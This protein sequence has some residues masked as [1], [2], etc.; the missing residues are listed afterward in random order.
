LSASGSERNDEKNMARFLRLAPVG[1]TGRVQA[2]YNETFMNR[3]HPFLSR[4]CHFPIVRLAAALLV[5]L[6]LS[7]LASCGR[8]R[9]ALVYSDVGNAEVLDAVK[10]GGLKKV[11]ALLQHNP[12]LVSSR[13][14]YG[15]TPLHFAAFSGHKDV[16]ELLLAHGADVNAKT[17][18]GATPLFGAVTFDKKDVVELLLAN[19]AD[20]NAKAD[21]ETPLQ[22]AVAQGYK[23]VVELLLAHGSTRNTE[24]KR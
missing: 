9:D 12:G 22:A 24:A 13:D 5:A 20:I 21:G 2:Q 1:R 8:N 6:A 4:V 10:A 16:A 7:N 23:D 19:K 15:N 17:A 3:T 11:E 18:N 14:D